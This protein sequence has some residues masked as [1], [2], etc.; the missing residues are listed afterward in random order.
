M[1]VKTVKICQVSRVLVLFNWPNCEKGQSNE[2]LETRENQ[3]KSILE[4]F[5]T[6]DKI[7]VANPNRFFSESFQKTSKQILCSTKHQ[8]GSYYYAKPRNISSTNFEKK[9]FPLLFRF[10]WKIGLILTSAP[11]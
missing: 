8:S 2:G 5:E 7:A 4:T 9:S 1:D 10:F 6:L 11:L 3:N